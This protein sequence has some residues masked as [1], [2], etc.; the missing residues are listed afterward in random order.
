[1]DW[2]LLGIMSHVTWAIFG[3]E[4]IDLYN[5]ISIEK[6]RERKKWLM[7]T[8]CNVILYSSY[9][10]YASKVIRNKNIL[11]AFIA[12]HR[13]TII[14]SIFPFLFFSII[15]F[16]YIRLLLPDSYG[17]NYLF[18]WKIVKFTILMLTHRQFQREEKKTRRNNQ[19]SNQVTKLLNIWS[20]HFGSIT[21]R[22][23]MC[24]QTCILKS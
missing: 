18:A 4:F 22:Y 21:L 24:L 19:A 14:D 6:D 13:H 20:I 7:C 15:H 1:M 11:Y 5:I 8:W 16:S 23:E 17:S 10:Y 3:M 9:Q 2:E 12:S